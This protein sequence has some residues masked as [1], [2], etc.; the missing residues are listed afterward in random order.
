MCSV[1][2]NAASSISA[3]GPHHSLRWQASPLKPGKQ[4]HSPVE[5]SQLPAREHSDQ[6]PLP[7]ATF[8]AVALSAQAAPNSHPPAQEGV[9]LCVQGY[10]RSW[11]RHRL[12]LVAASSSVA[13]K[14]HTLATSS[15][16]AMPGAT[17]RAGAPG[18]RS[19]ERHGCSS[20]YNGAHDHV[21]KVGGSK[22]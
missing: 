21:D 14:A 10:G 15:T 18:W 17:Q 12:T 7:W 8:A 1:T 19:P 13:R 16:V 4:A 2:R 5:R 11:G 3:F 6:V 22:R 20:E 9:V